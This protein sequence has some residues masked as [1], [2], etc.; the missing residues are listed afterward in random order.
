MFSNYFTRGTTFVTSCLLPLLAKVFPKWG[1]Y[2]REIFFFLL[3]SK[4]IFHVSVDPIEM[5]GKMTELI[6]IPFE[7][8]RQN[9]AGTCV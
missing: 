3:K 8:E 5:G 4:S 2:L 1:L 6:S 9:A 7:S